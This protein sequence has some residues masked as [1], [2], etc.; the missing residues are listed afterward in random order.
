MQTTIR[1]TSSPTFGHSASLAH[2]PSLL[3]RCY[4]AQPNRSV[5]PASTQHDEAPPVCGVFSLAPYL[6]LTTMLSVYAHMAH[7]AARHVGSSHS[8]MLQHGRTPKLHRL[9]AG[10]EICHFQIRFQSMKKPPTSNPEWGASLRVS[11]LCEQVVILIRQPLG[12]I[13]VANG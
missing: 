11:I 2:G 1:T 4:P 7:C 8:S 13:G 12:L 3:I 10:V 5:S 9:Q 6:G